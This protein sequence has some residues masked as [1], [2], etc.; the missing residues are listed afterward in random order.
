V[1][2][3]EKPFELGKPVLYND[4]ILGGED[5]CMRQT[6]FLASLGG[7]A[8][9][10]WLGLLA[11][12]NNKYPD[13]LN[14]AIFLAIWL[15]AVSFTIVPVAYVINARALGARTRPRLLRT[16]AVRQGLFVGLVATAL[17]ALRFM[18]LLTP[19]TAVPL[20][21]VAILAEV[22]ISVRRR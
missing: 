12:M 17:M 13:S 6:T 8:L 18:R 2:A 5:R 16:R 7:L 3:P 22:V 15:A 4:L 10:L 11:F 19:I 20:I 9:L 14:Q 1:K 21:L